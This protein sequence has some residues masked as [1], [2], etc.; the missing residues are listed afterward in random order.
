M[1]L[2][3][4][5]IKDYD[6]YKSYR[7]TYK[8][9]YADDENHIYVFKNISGGSNPEY[10]ILKG[11]K[12]KNPDGNYVWKKGSDEDWGTYG[13]TVMGTEEYCQKKIKEKITL[14]CGVNNA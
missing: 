13:W 11:K 3:A 14:Q 7:R 12:I 1:K 6:E 4:K 10:E 9:V 8:K 5:D 2:F